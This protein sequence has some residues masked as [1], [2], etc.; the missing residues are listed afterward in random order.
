MGTYPSRR[1][2]AHETLQDK[3]ASAARIG[4][5][6]LGSRRG[7]AR[8]SLCIDIVDIA[9]EMLGKKVGGAVGALGGPSAGS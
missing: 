4:F 3:P 1:S 9:E 7:G 8:E 2:R 5:M 6:Q